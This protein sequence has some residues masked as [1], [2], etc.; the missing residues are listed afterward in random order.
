MDLTTAGPDT[1]AARPTPA[2]GLTTG[3]SAAADLVAVLLFV[4]LGR[5]AH[6]EGSFLAGTAA[7][8]WPFLAGAAVGWGLLLLRGRPA[9]S[10][11]RGGLVVL[12]A[13]VPIGMALRQ[14]AGRGVQPSFVLVATVFLTLFLVGHRLL[15]PVV[16][17]WAGRRP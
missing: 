17:R 16:R 14:L 4:V 7:V 2:A 9:P 8:A 11:V 12:A 1:G 13:T 3:V 6:D 10:S 15:V 5:R